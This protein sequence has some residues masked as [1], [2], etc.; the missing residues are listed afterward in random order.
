MGRVTK[1]LRDSM[2]GW[3]TDHFYFLDFRVLRVERQGARK[4]RN[5]ND[6]LASLAL[7]P[8]VTLPILE[9]WAKTG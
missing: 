8:L 1:G 4:S 6:R 3:L 2:P 9:L 5:K 7:N